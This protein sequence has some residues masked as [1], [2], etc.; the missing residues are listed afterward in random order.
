MMLPEY[1]RNDIE[2]CLVFHQ[3]NRRV[4]KFET[5]IRDERSTCRDTT[6]VFAVT[7]YLGRSPQRLR[8]EMG[9]SLRS[10]DAGKF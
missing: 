6:S 3:W 8:A 2:N 1:Q 4:L 5:R 10:H 9:I 7:L